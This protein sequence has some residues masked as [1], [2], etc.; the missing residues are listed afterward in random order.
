MIYCICVMF[1]AYKGKEEL[2]KLNAQS[3]SIGIYVS[4]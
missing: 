3:T 2:A 1:G 4:G